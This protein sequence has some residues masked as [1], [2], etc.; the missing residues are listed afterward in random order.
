VARPELGRLPVRAIALGL[1]DELEIAIESLEAGGA[2]RRGNLA[3]Q[4]GFGM[5]VGT[6]GCFGYGQ[7]NRAFVMPV[8]TIP[9][10]TIGGS[11]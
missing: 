6:A 3:L 1:A 2:Q 7:W 11:R 5:I 8:T 4:G 9:V 10:T